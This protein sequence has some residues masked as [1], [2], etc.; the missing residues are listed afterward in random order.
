[1]Q[2]RLIFSHQDGFPTPQALA[3]FVARDGRGG[4]TP[5]DASMFADAIEHGALIAILDDTE[6][7]IAMA[8]V[9][10]LDEGK[11][12]LGGALVRPDMTGFGLQKYMVQARLAVFRARKIAPWRQLYTGAA[13]ADYGAGSRKALT[14]AG[15]EGIAYEDGPRELREECETCTKTIPEGRVCCY[16]FYRAPDAGL[17]LGYQPGPVTIKHARDGRVLELLLSPLD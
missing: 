3:D 10:P 7:L 8:G 16:Q 13:H 4:L 2:A 9:L 12:E 5:R 14:G 17:P 11:F 1:M 6:T 15:F